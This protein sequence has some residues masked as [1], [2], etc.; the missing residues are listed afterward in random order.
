MIKGQNDLYEVLTLNDVKEKTPELE[1]FL[2]EIAK[3]AGAEKA[4]MFDGTIKL[5]NKPDNVE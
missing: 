1:Q 3:A 4:I 2:L 5:L